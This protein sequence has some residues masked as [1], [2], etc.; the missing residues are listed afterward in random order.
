MHRI[1]SLQS[2]AKAAGGSWVEPRKEFGKSMEM[3]LK[4]KGRWI[5]CLISLDLVM[6][7]GTLGLVF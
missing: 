3:E 6:L 7:I 2:E 4:E 5:V 1:W